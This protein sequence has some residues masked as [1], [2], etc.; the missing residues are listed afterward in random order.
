MPGNSLRGSDLTEFVSGLFD[1]FAAARADTE[2]RWDE[3]RRDFLGEF[4]AIWKVEEGEDWRS[5]ATA[6][7]A[8]QK[9]L[10]AYS[11]IVDLTL[12]GGHIPMDMRPSRRLMDSLPDA[13]T[14]FSQALE[15]SKAQIT[16][17]LDRCHADR[18][19]MLNILSG[20]I[21]G[22]TWAKKTVESFEESVNRPVAPVPGM[23]VDETAPGVEFEPAVETI[24]GPGWRYRSVWDIFGDPEYVDPRDPDSAGTFDRQMVTP[25]WLRRKKGQPFWIDDAIDACVSDAAKAKP[26]GAATGSTSDTS[27][28]SLPPYL[29]DLKARRRS[30]RL[31][32]GWLWAPRAKVEAFEAELAA[33]MRQTDA[34]YEL[35]RVGTRPEDDN[36]GDD[37]YVM[38]CLADREIV[39]YARVSPKEM[40][41]FMADFERALDERNGRGVV[42]NAKA[43]HE[44]VS[45]TLRAIEDNM[46]WACN[47]QAVMRSKM[48]KK[49]PKSMKP[50]QLMEVNETCQRAADAIEQIVIQDVSGPLSNYLLPLWEKYADWDTMLPKITQGQ[51]EK[52]AATATEITAQQQRA[53]AYIGTAL[54]NFDEGLI[55][56]MVQAFH[57]DNMLDPSITAGR[58]DFVVQALGYEAYQDRLRR[59]TKLRDALLLAMSDPEL[60]A[61]TKLRKIFE[62]LLKAMGIDVEG[63]LKSDAEKQQE[64]ENAAA[65]AQGPAADPSAQDRNAAAAEKD[66]AHAAAITKKANVDAAKVELEAERLERERQQPAGAAAPGPVAPR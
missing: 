10:T 43:A 61:E 60:R 44:G 14:A 30:I 50:G 62:P 36:S 39:R 63:A 12:Q 35:P 53:D 40:P 22:R 55:E 41:L 26:S 11:I 1:D 27:E 58:G 4:R 16:K 20:C 37:V 23:M 54:R 51:I 18:E 48:F 15:E 9:A 52:N 28:T 25:R 59:V 45:K 49:T 66:R 24:T 65:A 21:Y 8:R 34:E 31:L 57:D 32:E 64:A 38:V 6:G 7:I 2:R 42:D 19:Y 47:V 17:Q 13:E 56:P 29:R 46:A 5:K 3:N 33:K